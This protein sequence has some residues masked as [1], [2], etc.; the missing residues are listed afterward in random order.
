MAAALTL[1]GRSSGSAYPHGQCGVPQQ[2]FSHDQ[3]DWYDG[4]F[5]GRILWPLPEVN[6]PDAHVLE[7]LSNMNSALVLL[8]SLCRTTVYPYVPL[9]DP[10]FGSESVVVYLVKSGHQG[11]GALAAQCE[12]VVYGDRDLVTE[13]K[14]P[15]HTA[16]LAG[17]VLIRVWKTLHD[18]DRFMVRSFKKTMW[19]CTTPSFMNRRPSHTG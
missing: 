19:L 9:L 18:K 8:V 2:C 13:L 6:D 12:S 4:L 14:G 11:W 15:W 16:E 7:N 1:T 10:F 17:M 3:I 5:K